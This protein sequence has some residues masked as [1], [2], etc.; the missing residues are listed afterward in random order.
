MVVA[1][2]DRRIGAWPS[3]SPTT[4]ATGRSSAA[5]WRFVWGAPRADTMIVDAS[6][7]AH[8]TRIASKMAVVADGRGREAVTHYDVVESFPRHA[9]EPR[10]S[11][12]RAG[13]RPG[14]RTRSACIWPT[15]AIR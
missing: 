10:R 8:P 15:S 6:D 4:A 2:T 13:W 1:K 3:N 12:I 11:R 5:I 7:R 9:A 14:A